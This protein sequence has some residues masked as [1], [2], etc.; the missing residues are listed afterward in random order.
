MFVTDDLWGRY[1]VLEWGLQERDCKGD[2][3]FGGSG[4]NSPPEKIF[5]IEDLEK[6][7]SGILRPSQC[8]IMS[9]YF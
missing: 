1:R 6:G 2:P 7:I 5:K 3:P 4:D 8:V 9:H